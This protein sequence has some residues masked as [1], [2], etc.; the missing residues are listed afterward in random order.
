MHDADA[1]AAPL[2]PGSA[3]PD[4]PPRTSSRWRRGAVTLAL[5]GAVLALDAGPVRA[6]LSAA[7]TQLTPIR[8]RTV[9]HLPRSGNAQHVLGYDTGFSHVRNG[10]AY[11][12]FGDSLIDRSSG[13]Y[14]DEIG[15]HPQ[16]GTLGRTTD[17]KARDCVDV[18][19]ASSDGRNVLPVPGEPGDVLRWPGAAFD[20]GG[21]LYFLFSVLSADGW[22]VALGGI[23]APTRNDLGLVRRSGRQ[24]APGERGYGSGIDI[25]GRVYLLSYDQITAEARLARVPQAQIADVGSYEY[26]AGS[27]WS[28]DPDAATPILHGVDNDPNVAYFPAIDR[29]VIVYTCYWGAA[30]CASTATLNGRGE[31]A[32]EGW[33]TPTA[34]LSSTFAGHGFWH[35]GYADPAHPERMYVTASRLPQLG[36]YWVTLYEID[37]DDKLA[38]TRPVTVSASQDDDFRTIQDERGWSYAS[39]VRGALATTLTELSTVVPAAPPARRYA[40]WVGDEVADGPTVP[41]IVNAPG[42]APRSIF[43]SPTRAGAKVYTVPVDGTAEVSGEAWLERTCGDGVIAEVQLL[44]GDQVR[45]VWRKK[46]KS[47]WSRQRARRV[48]DVKNIA[49]QTGDRLV[50]GVG[51]QTG[52]TATCDLAYFLTSVVVVPGGS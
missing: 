1:P 49:V 34:I 16:T 3:V 50:F 26:F 32:M 38:P 4:V 40:V 28:S 18:G 48:Y 7:T 21:S 52:R 42:A 36:D 33:N 9:C 14:D 11:W 12:S 46:L 37:V 30:V 27:G 19:L 47:A 2:S 35:A 25:D 24:W 31:K 22:G 20:A 8:T 41:G 5:V 15:D 17:L 13:V 23:S 39:Y 44:H 51:N 6:V 29:Y 10:V 45:T 43:P